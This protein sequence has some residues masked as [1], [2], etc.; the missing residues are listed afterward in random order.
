MS[1]MID[2]VRNT[3]EGADA[4]RDQLRHGDVEPRRQ[5]R[6]AVEL[7]EVVPGST[8]DGR[9]E[10]RR[11]I[12]RGG[13]AT[14]CEGRH[15]LSNAKVALKLLQAP[16]ARRA[17]AHARLVAESRALAALRHPNIIGLHDAGRCDTHGPY[18]ALEMITGRPLE[19]L[20][21]TRPQL[22]VAQTVALIV[23]LCAALEEVHRCKLLHRDVKPA[24][25]MIARDR[26]ADQVKLIDFG[27]ARASSTDDVEA[28]LTKEGELLGTVAYMAPEQIGSSDVDARADVYSAAVVLY[29]CLSGELPYAGSNALQLLAAQMTGGPP[30]ALSEKHPELAAFDEV[31]RRGLSYDRAQRF[32]TA[33]ELAVA[34]VK[35]FNKPVPALGLLDRNDEYRQ[36]PSPASLAPMTPDH[37]PAGEPLPALRRQFARA[38]YVTPV[39]LLWDQG[40]MDG[41]TADISEGGMMVMTSGPFKEV[42][43]VKVRVPLPSS[44]RVAAL[45]ARAKWAKD[46]RGQSA[47]G[48]EFLDVPEPVRLDIRS[49][50]AIMT[51]APQ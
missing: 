36:S 25:I 38:T 31:V 26:S 13:I 28:R 37:P 12:A 46:S 27:V 40:S 9:Y 5:R 21:V 22:P 35:A 10:V 2:R 48:L 3:G 33:R 51:G 4:R 11:E 49:Y 7:I 24:N 47:I 18:L 8:V 42:A 17:S 23:Q 43:L 16:A 45:Q 44:G 50:V 1:D 30:P 14:V 6:R 41:R 34:L 29:E 39:R 32:A 15:L 19:G 20:L